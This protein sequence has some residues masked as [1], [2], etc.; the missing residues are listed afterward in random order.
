MVRG[1]STPPHISGPPLYLQYVLARMLKF[2]KQ[3]YV[4]KSLGLR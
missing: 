3:V 2:G 4:G 1:Y